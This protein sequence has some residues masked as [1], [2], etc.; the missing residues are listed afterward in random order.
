MSERMTYAPDTVTTDLRQRLRDP[1]YFALHLKAATAIRNVASLGWYD[2]HFLRRYEIARHYLAD[3]CPDAL[4]GF[5]RGF[6]AL[7]P[8]EGFREMVMED[9]FD[10]ATCA[11]I[12]AASRSAE[13]DAANEQATENRQFGRDVVW[14]HPYF[15]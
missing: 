4:P 12:L 11:A 15:L 7:K 8:P 6:D 3:V 1:A 10:P 9:V 14:D 5:V 2:S 13:P